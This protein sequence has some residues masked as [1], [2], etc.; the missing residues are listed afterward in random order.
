VFESLTARLEQTLRRLRGRGRLGEGDLKGAMREI[1]VALLEADV[2]LKVAQEFIG[3]VRERALGAEVLESLT[4]GQ[5]VVKIVHDELIDLMGREGEGLAPPSGPGPLRVLIVGLQGSGKTTTAAKLAGLLRRRGRRPLLVAAD[6]QRPAAVQQLQVV[7]S[8][9]ETPVFAVPGASDPVAVCRRA[10]KEAQSAGQD[11]VIVDT[12]GRLH[13][14]EGLMDELRRVRSALEPEEVLLVVDAMTGQDAVTAARAFNEGAG[15]TG[16]ILTKLDGDARGGA[17]L[18]VRA[19]TGRPIKFVGLGEKLDALE[20]FHP[21]RLAS[22][23]LGMGDVLSLVERAQSAMD[24]KEAARLQRHL[25]GEEFTLSDFLEQL[26]QVRK[27]GGLDDLMGML[28]TAGPARQLKNLKVDPRQ[29]ARTEAII[30]SMTAEERKHPGIIGGSRRRRV[31]RGSGTS[32]Q[33]VN[34]LLKQ[35]EQMRRLIKQLGSNRRGGLAG[36]LGSRGPWPQ[37]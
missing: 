33:D 13:V 34:R 24:D 23:I 30:N 4:P 5:Q 1:R 20:P 16:V 17:A 31:A 32:I 25:Q 26:H 35:Y 9:V 6:L 15:V 37:P 28:P 11:V 21:D 2:N 14:D 3:R 36:L 18:S 7:G 8:Q 10:M 29:L 12:A 27:M 22:R 19:V